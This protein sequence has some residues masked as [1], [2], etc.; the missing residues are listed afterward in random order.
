MDLQCGL[1]R[2]LQC[3]LQCV[4]QCGLQCGWVSGHYHLVCVGTAATQEEIQRVS[5]L[6]RTCKLVKGQLFVLSV[7]GRLETTAKYVA[8]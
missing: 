4:L 8:Q 7:P 5:D 3:G 6:Y 2:G 1:Q